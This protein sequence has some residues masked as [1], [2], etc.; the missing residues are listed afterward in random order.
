MAFL[1][2][3]NISVL[4]FLAKGKYIFQLIFNPVRMRCTQGVKSIQGTSKTK[5]SVLMFIRR[6]EKKCPNKDIS[7]ANSKSAL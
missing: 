3:P 7:N 1:I 6:E 4:I 5:T 2:K